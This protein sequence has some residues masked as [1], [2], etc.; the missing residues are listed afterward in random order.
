MFVWQHL[1][2]EE[3]A[4]VLA[5][6]RHMPAEE[7]QCFR[8]RKPTFRCGAAVCQRTAVPGPVPPASAPGGLHPCTCAERGLVCAHGRTSAKISPRALRSRHARTAPTRNPC[9]ESS[10]SLALRQQHRKE[11]HRKERR[12]FLCRTTCHPRADGK[13]SRQSPARR[14]CTRAT[15][16]EPGE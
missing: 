6:R 16:P 4:C 5:G 12:A 2:V 13:D 10:A 11:R 8:T 14:A 9:A 3:V 1:A 7:R 15:F